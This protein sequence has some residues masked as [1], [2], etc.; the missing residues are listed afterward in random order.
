MS[1]R[2]KLES[3]FQRH[4]YSDFKW[5]DPKE[6]VVAHWVRMKCMFGC[7]E[8][9]HTASCPPNVPS[10]EECQKF[11]KDYDEAAIFHFAGAVPKPGDRHDWTRKLNQKLLDLEKDVFT[12]GYE[13]VFLLF[14]DSCNICKSCRETREE[15]K[16]PKLSRPTPEAL[17]MDVF[18]TVRKVGYSIEVLSDYS[19]EMNRFAFLLIK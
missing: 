8:Y 13:K 7:K 19:Q 9:G 1:D 6:F 5:I 11:F 17:A 2:H 14:L 16:E 12:S 10:V 4:G 15:C 3:I 18:S